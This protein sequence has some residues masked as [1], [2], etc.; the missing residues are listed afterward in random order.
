M[1]RAWS[2]R[3]GPSW[4]TRTPGRR[5][6]PS[7]RASVPIIVRSSAVVGDV[8]GGD[9]GRTV[10]AR[11]AHAILAPMRGRP[12]RRLQV[13][14]ARRVSPSRSLLASC[15]S[16]PLVAAP[17]TS[18]GSTHD[19]DRRRPRRP[20]RAGHA[21][22]TC[23]R[24][25][26]RAR[27]PGRA[28]CAA[29]R[30][31]TASPRRR[32]PTVPC[33]SR[34]RTRPVRRRRWPGWSTGTGRPP[35]PSTWR[36]A[37]PRWPPTAPT[38]TSPPTPNVFAYSRSSGN[39]DGQWNL[40]PM[41]RGE[42]LRREP[43]LPRRGGRHRAGLDDA[44]QHRERLPDRPRVLGR[45]PL[46][47][48]GLGAAVGS[49]GSIYYESDRPP[50]RR[51]A[52]RT[53][54]TTVGPALADTAQRPGRRACSTS[55]SWPAG[56]VWVCEP[57]GQGLDASYTT[58][59]A[60][61]LAAVGTL[62]RLGH[63]AAWSTPRPGPSCSS[64][65]RMRPPAR[66]PRPRPRRASSAS[67]PTARPATPSGVGAAVTLLGPAPAVVASDTTTGQFDLVRLS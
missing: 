9:H 22:S 47:L 37:S 3:P 14:L 67:T 60:T 55:T 57:A 16:G 51:A 66:R 6:S 59:D 50:P 56:A 25:P 43:R 24:W 64:P 41:Q 53:A 19:D 49:D 58:Y 4:Q 48:R 13:G 33:S 42:Q 15:S 18:T 46:L 44:G 2:S 45:A 12:G 30:R 29:V 32:A 35:S 52:P 54:S 36:P 17:A 23:R 5:S 10:V 21:A 8:A 38:S 39:Q 40:P 27:S 62:Q 1:A 63:R 11:A 28:D 31:R 65:A 7:G 34:R 61:S 20:H 26:R